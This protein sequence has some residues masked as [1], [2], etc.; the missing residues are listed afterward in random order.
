MTFLKTSTLALAAMLLLAPL[1]VGTASAAMAAEQP[2]PIDISVKIPETIGSPQEFMVT[3]AQF[4]W[5]LNKEATS[6]AHFGGCNF[7][8]AGIA[9]DTGSSRIWTASDGFYSAKS[10]DARIEK[11]NATGKWIADSWDNK[12]LDA[13]GR[14]VG[15]TA[16]EQGTGAQV[17]I[18]GGSGNINAANGTA[19]IRWKGSFSVAMYG[20]MTY[21]S[22]TDPV[23]SV[24]NGKGTLRATLSGYGSD[25]MDTTKW[26]KIAPREITLATMPGVTLGEHG[27]VAQPAYKRVKIDGVEPAQVRDGSNWGS[28]PSDFVKFQVQTGQGSYWYSSGVGDNRKLASTV[29]TSYTPDVSVVPT[30]PPDTTDPGSGG[31]DS[32]T[33][34]QD[35]T[36][37]G[38]GSDGDSPGAGGSVAGSG[39]GQGTVIG[40]GTVL[41]APPAGT[42]FAAATAAAVGAANWL[43]GSLIPEA[44][45]LAKDR[46][47]FLLW[48]IAGLLGLTALS[49]VGF[50]RGW[51]VLPFTKPNPDN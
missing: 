25:R 11:P 35:G 30:T 6:G 36:G 23:L 49:W 34:D 1:S 22:A 7:L 10:G 48:S 13:S 28:F 9:G 3:D 19:E 18:D 42:V 39:P 15:T 4:R 45:E 26:S 8:S 40:N 43:G 21:W 2:Q 37:T 27:I 41:D 32:G 46:R 29:Y 20:G 51:F 16:N 44:I 17:V 47:E 14:E 5:G 33:G 50:R 24:A 31:T 38:S 12:C